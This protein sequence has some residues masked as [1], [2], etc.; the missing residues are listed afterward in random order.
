MSPEQARGKPVDEGGHIWAFGVVLYEMLT[1]RSCFAKET[2]SDT[3]AGAEGRKPIGRACRYR[4]PPSGALR[5]GTVAAPSRHRRCRWIIDVT[6]PRRQ[7][8]HRGDGFPGRWLACSPGRD[9]PVDCPPAAQLVDRPLVRLDLD[10]QGE[11]P[12]PALG[13]MASRDGTRLVITTTGR[14]GQSMLATRRVD[15]RENMVLD[16]TEGADQPS[17]RPDGERIAFFAGGKLKNMLIQAGRH[18][19]CRRRTARGGSWAWT[20]HRRSPVQHDGLWRV[21]RKGGS[22]QPLTTLQTAG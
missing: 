2:V 14:D 10:V 8:G 9:W 4:P 19:P 21:P 12:A 16:G 22:P 15:E 13:L 3:V 17:S 11:V 5:E 1:G 6:G 7:Q 20:G 18:R